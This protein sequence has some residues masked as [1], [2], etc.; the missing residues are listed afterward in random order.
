MNVARGKRSDPRSRRSRKEEEEEE[1]AER[2][3][4]LRIYYRY[5]SLTSLRSRVVPLTVA[6]EE[7]KKRYHAD[8]ITLSNPSNPPLCFACPF[9]GPRCARYSNT[10]LLSLTQSLLSSFSCVPPSFSLSLS[11]TLSLFFFLFVTSIPSAALSLLHASLR[12]LPPKLQACEP[13]VPC[14]C[15][16][17]NDLAFSSLSLASSLPSS[18]S[19][20]LALSSPRR[21][22]TPRLDLAVY[23]RTY[24]GA[25]RKFIGPRSENH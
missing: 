22:P 3:A 15:Y 20:L 5:I 24:T 10:L 16:L 21:G 2:G 18:L 13:T 19:L 7:K 9:I 23:V 14:N 11:P 17:G 4:P 6:A 25:R 8:S 1:A 12:P